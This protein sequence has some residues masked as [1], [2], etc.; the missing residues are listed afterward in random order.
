MCEYRRKLSIFTWEDYMSKQNKDALIIGLALF[1]MFFGAGNLIF[2]PQIGLRTGTNW[3]L[4]AGGFL[5]TG[6][7]LPLFGIFASI[8]G[9]EAL[10]RFQPRIGKKA[11]IIFQ[12]F[13]A[14]TIG[15]AAVPRTGATTHE[16]G[17]SLLIPGISPFVTA[18]I[19]FGLTLVLAIKPTGIM[20]RIG[21]FLTPV[22][23]TILAII[24]IKGIVDPLT[25]TAPST[26]TNEFGEGFMGGYQTM[27][28]LGALIFGGIMLNTFREKG[29][30][31]PKEQMRMTTKAGLIALIGLGV[32]Y[33]GLMFLGST[34]AADAPADISRTSLTVLI[35]N[36]LLGQT[37]TYML[38]VG[39]SFAC[40]TTSVGLI[41]T[42]A[43]FFK[44]FSKGK[45]PYK[46]VVIVMTIACA[47]VSIIGVDG[48]VQ[49]AGPIL[50]VL[51]PVAIM[52]NIF[53]FT[54]QWIESNLVIR[55]TLGVTFM[56][57]IVQGLE[58]GGILGE[59]P[60]QII[61]VIP[62]GSAG[63]PWIVPTVIT[64][65][66]TSIIAKATNNGAKRQIRQEYLSSK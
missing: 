38:G 24:I 49:V 13:V 63:F 30:N 43:E 7:G 55:L 15:F 62:L 37:G 23:V 66:I 40:L 32:V 17:F 59:L 6:I 47:M 14:L 28:A 2:P 1:A 12:I 45:V 8:K 60:T 25:G 10:E 58:A 31:T 11:L 35:S 9:G 42:I 21:K 4:A 46:F 53:I 29:Y 19:F 65:I 26:I 57:A 64:F 54:S 41:A 20:D 5:M 33:S 36:M 39:V 44:D 18:I 61:Q 16:I 51:Y 56:V 48:I 22:L 50:T 52:I 27:D 34:V 3:Y